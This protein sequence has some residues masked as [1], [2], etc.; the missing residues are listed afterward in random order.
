MSWP[1]G[2]NFLLIWGKGFRRNPNPPPDNS[3]QSFISVQFSSR[4]APSQ[5][6]SGSQ[7]CAFKV[8]KALTD[9]G[10]RTRP[11]TSPLSSFGVCQ[12]M[13]L[14]FP[15]GLYAKRRWLCPQSLILDLLCSHSM[16]LTLLTL[17]VALLPLCILNSFFCPVPHLTQACSYLSFLLSLCG[18]LV[19]P[20]CITPTPPI[21]IRL[22]LVPRELIQMDVRPQKAPNHDTSTPTNSLITVY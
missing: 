15:P 16:V 1:T 7:V 4:A 3:A 11:N 14:L 9:S 12:L 20:W 21:V 18:Q 2:S 8:T 6:P 13:I 22:G 10:P 19:G 17:Y 5:Y